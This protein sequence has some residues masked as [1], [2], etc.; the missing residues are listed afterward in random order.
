M[1]KLTLILFSVQLCFAQGT[2]LFQ[3][4]F[5]DNANNWHVGQDLD[6]KAEINQGK[7]MIEH[8][9][10]NNSIVIPKTVKIDPSQDYFIEC[11]TLWI[12]GKEDYPYGLY[13]GG[14]DGNNYLN[15]CIS[16]NGYFKYSLNIDGNYRDLIKPTKSAHINVSG[17]NKLT[18]IKSSNTLIFFINSEQV[19]TYNYDGIFGNKVGFIIFN[20]QKIAF[21]DLSIGLLS[22]KKTLEPDQNNS[23][24]KGNGSGFFI[25]EKGYVATNYHVIKDANTIQIEY[26]Q[27]G[28]KNTFA[29]KVIVIDKQN[30]LAII[31]INDPQFKTLPSIPYVFSTR[32]KEVGSEVFTLGYPIANVMGDEIKFTDGKISSKTGIDG[33]I[34]VYQI[35]VPMQPGNSGGPLFDNMGN[36]VGITSSALNKEYF[37]S[38]NVNYAIK[39]IYLKSLIDVMPESITL[40]NNIEIYNKQLTEKIKILSDFIPI[41]RVK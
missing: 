12:S 41:I 23:Q 6:W 13:F 5:N 39:T 8:F 9:L 31:R 40:P 10:E 25:N 30:D 28:I 27:K 2:Y 19:A 18:V 7:F 20:A 32:S 22:N 21:D 24:W 26:F 4:F 14:M 35:S 15:F 1:Y 3:D 36:L 34:T 16:A 37:N 17:S 11:S 33:N 29:A 38:E